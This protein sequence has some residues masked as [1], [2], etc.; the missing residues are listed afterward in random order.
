M[1]HLLGNHRTLLSEGYCKGPVKWLTRVNPAIIFSSLEV[2]CLG[3]EYEKSCKATE[4][5]QIA[6]QHHQRIYKTLY[7]GLVAP[8]SKL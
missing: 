6:S 4:P 2:C 1:C 8:V 7:R 5:S 3:A